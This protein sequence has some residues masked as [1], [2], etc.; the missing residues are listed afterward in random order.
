MRDIINGDLAAV[1]RQRQD[2]ER[3]RVLDDIPLGSD[4]VAAKLEAL[5]GDRLRAVFD[6]VAVITIQPVGKGGHTFDPDRVDVVW[7]D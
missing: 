6:V 2:A 7:K 1:E 4:R 5:S 3:K